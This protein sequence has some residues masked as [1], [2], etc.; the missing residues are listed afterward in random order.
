[1][2]RFILR[3]GPVR[4]LFV[5]EMASQAAGWGRQAVWA[6]VFHP[7]NHEF[8]P[9]V[10]AMATFVPVR[11]K[12]L[13]LGAWI[14]SNFVVESRRCAVKEQGRRIYHIIKY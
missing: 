12:R 11:G 7:H 5:C 4:P 8:L 6:F 2:P 1:M 14:L 13:L 3:C 9:L 10:H